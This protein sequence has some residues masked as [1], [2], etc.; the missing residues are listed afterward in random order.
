ME[1]DAAVDT[2]IDKEWVGGN[3]YIAI[4]VA[5]HHVLRVLFRVD[6]AEDAMEGTLSPSTKFFTSSMLVDI[7]GL[8]KRM[9]S[10]TKKKKDDKQN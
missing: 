1:H 2:A 4:N 6:L 9:T 10:K 3:V 8:N 5:V 7:T